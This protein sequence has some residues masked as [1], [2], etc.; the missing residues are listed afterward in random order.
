MTYTPP[1][2]PGQPL[3][4]AHKP[5][6]AACLRIYL[7]ERGWS[8]PQLV[9]A[10]GWQNQPSEWLAAVSALAQELGFEIKPVKPVKPAPDEDEEPAIVPVP[11]MPPEPVTNIIRLAD[12]R[13][14]AAWIVGGETV[15]LV[16]TS[17][18]APV[19]RAPAPW[20]VDGETDHDR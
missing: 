12:R 9:K 6:L 1:G 11:L 16:P 7:G 19:E 15:P 3:P 10:M 5:Y 17:T 4:D 14:P 18:P 2:Q 20:T 13:E 8:F